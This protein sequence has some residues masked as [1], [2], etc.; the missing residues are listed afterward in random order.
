MNTEIMLFIT[1]HCVVGPGYLSASASLYASYQQQN[2][3]GHLSRN[4][5]LNGLK[6]SLEGV[7]R[8]GVHWDGK[9]SVRGFKGLGLKGASRP[10]CCPTCNRPY[11]EK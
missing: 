8:Y 9:K 10:S 4:E 1:Q 2:P 6:S 3:E 11:D 7:A 5:F